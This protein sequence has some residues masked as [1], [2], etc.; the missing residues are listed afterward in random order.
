MSA[1]RKIF[2]IRPC[3]LGDTIFTEPVVATLHN[4]YRK[5]DITFA[6]NSDYCWLLHKP[7][8]VRTMSSNIFG[9]GRKDTSCF[10]QHDIS[11]IFLPRIE[12]WAKA[13]GGECKHLIFHDPRPPRGVHI[14][15]HLLGALEPLG[16]KPLRREPRITAQKAKDSRGCVVIHPGSGGKHKLWPAGFW[17]ELIRK[18][19]KRVILTCGP[20][21]ADIVG[22]LAATTHR[23][24]TLL[25]NFEI[26]SLAE[27]LAG[28]DAYVGVDSGV[29]HLAAA[30]GVP[31]FAIYGPTEPA[32]WG[33]RGKRVHVF[34]NGRECADVTPEEVFAAMKISL[35]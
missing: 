31:T 9:L 33:P 4:K 17:S 28:V 25:S 35:V 11:L 13:Q 2:I 1:V 5:A 19:D 18:L 27:M 12:E 23:R 26:T 20:A 21:D 24:L 15:D 7:Y 14:V 22:E 10:N 8:S 32:E 3:A 16:I 6:G 29:T 34:R 30:L